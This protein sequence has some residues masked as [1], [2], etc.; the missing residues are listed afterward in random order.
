MDSPA[1]HMTLTLTRLNT[2][3][4]PVERSPTALY[5]D[6]AKNQC[7][8]HR[9]R[10]MRVISVFWDEIVAAC[11]IVKGLS[12]IS[13]LDRCRRR[14][15]RACALSSLIS[16]YAVNWMLQRIEDSVDGTIDYE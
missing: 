7:W 3:L 5:L 6:P 8:R 16:L 10:A 4:T 11:G 1:K 15:L 14:H 2:V 9:E 12:A 13:L